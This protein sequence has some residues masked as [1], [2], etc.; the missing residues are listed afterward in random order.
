MIN[1]R[2]V[3]ILELGSEYTKNLPLAMFIGFLF[4]YEILSI[5]PFTF[6]NISLLSL[7][8]DL[9]NYLNC[10]LLGLDYNSLNNNL[11]STINPF[12]YD[13]SVNN[14]FQIEV[15]AYMLYTYGS[16]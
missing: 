16:V 1:I 6:N 14:N 2:L 8:S 5:L 9:L 12:L 10:L 4:I 15:L 11:N 13:T 7:P 3:D